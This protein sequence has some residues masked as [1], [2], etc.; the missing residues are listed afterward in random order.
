MGN[1]NTDKVTDILEEFFKL[2][3]KTEDMALKIGI[4]GLTHTEL[5]II[6]AIGRDTLTMHELSDRLGIT[7]GTATVAINK[8]SEKKFVIR[9]RSDADRRKV[10]VNLDVKGKEALAYHDSYHNMLLSSI[11]ETIS[12]ERL[13]QFLATFEIILGN[14]SKKTEFF[15]PQ[16]V[17]EFQTGTKVSIISIEGTPI[18]KNYFA[19]K[20]IVT[21]SKIEVLKTKPDTVIIT[22]G[23]EE[24]TL[25]AED[26]KYLI[27]VKI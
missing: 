22:E 16:T 10:F 3:Y 24:L 26:A 13:E 1:R 12:D 19:A 15:K 20:G 2:F 21:F 11:T 23:G 7:M 4:Q 25:D 14:L 17:N 5:H 6:D 27:G 9:K 8:L 18:I